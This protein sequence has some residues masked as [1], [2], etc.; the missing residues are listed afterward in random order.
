MGPSIAESTW[1]FTNICHHNI[2]TEQRW[3]WAANHRP[4]LAGWCSPGGSLW[5]G[6]AGN[7][8]SSGR[9]AGRHEGLHPV[10]CH[11]MSV[12]TGHS[13]QRWV[14]SLNNS[15]IHTGVDWRFSFCWSSVWPSVWQ[16]CFNLAMCQMCGSKRPLMARKHTANVCKLPFPIFL[17]L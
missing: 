13:G 15:E 14:A 17:L 7:S 11:S 5:K 1:R 12:P 6:A 8:S 2:S 9:R 16:R 3:R 10:V 4:V